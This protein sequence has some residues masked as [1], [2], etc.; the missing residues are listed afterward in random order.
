MT[1]VSQVPVALLEQASEALLDHLADPQG[2]LPQLSG[3]PRD[4][5]L[6]ASHR[7]RALLNLVFSGTPMPF[8]VAR[9]ADGTTVINTALFHAAAVAPLMADAFTTPDQLAFHPDVLKRHALAIVD[10][11]GNA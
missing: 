8:W 10:P 3:A 1:S 11:L 5:L 9:S 7:L 4:Q 2:A 6:A